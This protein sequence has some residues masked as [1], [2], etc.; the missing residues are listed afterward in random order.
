MR[1]DMLQGAIAGIAIRASGIEAGNSP[2]DCRAVLKNR[3]H[4]DRPRV[5]TS[6]EALQIANDESLDLFL[7]DGQ[8]VHA[9]GSLP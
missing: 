4:D 3:Y 8:L 9:P 5:S 7:G 2:T 6:G 1:H